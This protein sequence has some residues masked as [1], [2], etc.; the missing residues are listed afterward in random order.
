MTSKPS[1]GRAGNQ[2][3]REHARSWV[4]LYR[5]ALKEPDGRYCVNRDAP[6]D[7]QVFICVDDTEPLLQLL[8]CFAKTGKFLP[9]DTIGIQGWLLRFEIEQLRKGGKVHGGAIQAIADKHSLHKKKVER[10]IRQV[11]DKK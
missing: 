6:S 3:E 1:K 9:K 8:D 2:A 11:N 7:E 5:L 10:L 4:E